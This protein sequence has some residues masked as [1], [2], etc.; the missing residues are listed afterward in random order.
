MY[1][2]ENFLKSLR[3]GAS[4]EDI[5]KTLSKMLNM[6]VADFTKEE[7]IKKQKEAEK[8][9]EAKAIIISINN[10]LQKYISPDMKMESS[11]VDVAVD[12]L[13]QELDKISGLKSLMNSFNL[14]NIDEDKSNTPTVKEKSG[15]SC[16]DCKDYTCDDELEFDDD[17]NTKDIDDDILK[18]FLSSL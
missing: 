11:D 14:F 12:H 18:K 5:A 17:Y 6:A 3:A 15:C 1:S 2:K 13:L 16:S 8:R 4:P 9:A 10:F 7:E